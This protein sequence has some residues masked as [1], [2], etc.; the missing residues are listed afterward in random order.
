MILAVFDSEKPKEKYSVHRLVNVADC[1]QFVIVGDVQCF[2]F[3]VACH[4]L[5]R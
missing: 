2:S 4:P 5:Y 1:M 3:N